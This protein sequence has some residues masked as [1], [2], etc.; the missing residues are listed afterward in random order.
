[1]NILFIP[2]HT[3]YT[4]HE[5][6]FVRMNFFRLL[7]GSIGN[8]SPKRGQEV[9]LYVRIQGHKYYAEKPEESFLCFSERKTLIP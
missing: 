2:K 7:H 9:K 6:C 3:F 4:K 5:K 8:Q 1:M